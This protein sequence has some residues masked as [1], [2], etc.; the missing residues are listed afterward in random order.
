MIDAKLAI[1]LPAVLAR[2]PEL[3]FSFVLMYH[4]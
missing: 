3:L 4:G 1:N 2:I